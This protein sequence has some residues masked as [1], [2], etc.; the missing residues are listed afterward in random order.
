MVRRPAP[1][2]KGEGRGARRALAAHLEKRGEKGGGDRA[3]V[4]VV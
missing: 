2:R 1:D 4:G 3:C